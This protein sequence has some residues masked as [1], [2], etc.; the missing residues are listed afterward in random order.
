MK[1]FL[2]IVLV[3]DIGVLLVLL[4]L[5]AWNVWGLD[6][7]WYDFRR[8]VYELKDLMQPHKNPQIFAHHVENLNA[9]LQA[10]VFT[11]IFECVDTGRLLWKSLIVKPYRWLKWWWTNL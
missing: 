10:V 1:M 8:K 3:L 4:V 2:N 5:L 7:F 11:V 9:A 6:G